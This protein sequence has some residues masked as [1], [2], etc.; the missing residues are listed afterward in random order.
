LLFLVRLL[1]GYRSD[2][3]GKHM[4]KIIS[5]SNPS[6]L[7]IASIQMDV[8]DRL[9]QDNR[10]RA[11]ALIDRAAGSDLIVL[12]ELWN[13]GYFS[14]DKYQIGS[15]T[16]EG[17]TIEMIRAKAREHRVCIMSGSIIE[18]EGDN[19]FNTN[20]LIDSE[21]KILGKYRKIHLFGFGSKEK[22]LLTAGTDVVALRTAFG[23]VGLS[24]C[25]DLRFPELF[26]SM[27]EMGAEVFIVSSAWPKA[28]LN[29]WILF[30]QAR[31]LENLS[32]LISANCVGVS[33]GVELA[34]HSMVVDPYGNPIADAGESE[35]IMT[36]TIDLKEVS[37]ARSEFPAVEDRVLR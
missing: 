37:K 18:R 35:A 2:N 4:T 16:A 20:Y 1:S 7:K 10:T 24:T 8:S 33:G 13:V 29:H 11:A 22:Q 28:R 32:F 36:A 34:G 31:A 30:N 23:C 26:R 27:L 15:E 3:G 17:E 14:F 12:P 25:Y 5:V 19:L 6:T 9:P 21:G